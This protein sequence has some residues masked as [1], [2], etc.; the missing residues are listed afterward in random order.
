MTLS[1]LQISFALGPCGEYLP[2][3]QGE[4]IVFNGRPLLHQPDQPR[5]SF[6]SALLNFPLHGTVTFLPDPGRN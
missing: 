1:Q 6:V 2:P 4:P 3:D 5:N